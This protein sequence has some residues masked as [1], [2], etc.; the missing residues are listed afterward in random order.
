MRLL[1]YSCPGERVHNERS[2]ANRQRVRGLL[3]VS[4]CPSDDLTSLRDRRTPGT[5]KG[6]LSDTV[7]QKWTDC[8]RSSNI[9]W[10]YA[11]PGHGKSVQAAFL[12]DYFTKSGYKCPYY[13]FRHD[14]STKRSASSLLKSLAFQIARDIPAFEESLST[15]GEDGL[16]FE[17]MDARSIWHKLFL[18]ILFKMQ[19][20]DPLYWV[21]DALDESDSI[22]TVIDVLSTISSSNFPIHIIVFSRQ[23]PAISQGFDRI[24][25]VNPLTTINA[26]QNLDDIRLFAISEMKYMHGNGDFHKEIIDQIVNRAEGSFL[27][28]DLVLKEIMQCHSYEEIKIAFDEIPSGMDSL[29]RRMET[30]IKNLTRVSDKDLARTILILATYSRRPLTTDEMLQALQPQF[31]AVL[32]LRFTIS[33]VCG[34]FVTIDSNSHIGLVHRTAREYLTKSSELPFSISPHDAH[35]DLSSKTISIFLDRQIRSIAA[36]KPIIPFYAYSS[37]SWAYHLNFSSAASDATLTLLIRFLKGS[38][39][40]SWIHMLAVLGQLKVLIF[41]AQGLTTYVQKRRKS[42]ASKMPLLHRLSDLHILELWAIDLLKLTGKFGSHLLQ[43]PTGIYK[44]VPQFSPRN[45]ALFQ[46]FGTSNVSPLSVTGLSD[47]DWDDCLTRVSVGSEHQAL[48]AICSGR[49]LA[50]L[51]ST[52]TVQVWNSLTFEKMCTFSHQEHIFTMCFSLKG[53]MIATYGFLTTRIW[54]ITSKRQLFTIS[55]PTGIRPLCMMFTKNDATILMGSDIRN[56]REL[57][58]Q[59]V[60]QGWQECEISKFSEETP[61]KG[62]FSNAP[63]A[64]AINGDATEIAIAYRGSPLTVWALTEPKC[65]SKCKRRLEYDKNPANAWTGVN[66]VLWH[67]NSGE[68]LGIYVDGAVFKWH[69]FEGNHHELT[70]SS[71]DTPSELDCSL[72]GIV[73][74]TS[75]VNGTVKIYNYEHFALIYQLSSED[76]VT[77]LCFSPDIRRFYD[78]RGSYCNAWEPNVLIR[79]SNADEAVSDIDTEVGSTTVSYL[80]SEVWAEIRAPITAVSAK[81]QG[82]LVCTG[83]DEGRVELHDIVDRKKLVVGESAAEM[84]IDQIVWDE[85]GRH[86]ARAE[87]GGRIIIRSIQQFHAK[88]NGEFGW[89]C[90]PAVSFKASVE[91]GGIAQILFSPDSSF[92][93]VASLNSAQLWS[94]QS[95]SIRSVYMSPTPGV[96]Y[97]WV[98]HPSKKDD[99]LVFSAT[100]IIALGWTDLRKKGQWKIGLPTMMGGS[101]EMVAHRQ[102]SWLLQNSSGNPMS[103][104]GAGDAIDQVIM[105]QNSSYILTCLSQHSLQSNQSHR[106]RFYLIELN[107]L[108]PI[109]AEASA[110]IDATFPIP[111]SIAVTIEKPLTILGEDLLVYLDKSFWVCSC[112]IN[113]N[114]T[115]RLVTEDEHEH[116]HDHEREDA[117]TTRRHFFL[118]RDWVDAESL[119]L[120]RI[121]ADGTLL[122]P[123]KGELAV[124]R[125]D[126][127]SEW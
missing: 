67:P 53:E 123:R 97:K 52:G 73:F 51:S 22:S 19:G 5:C 14:D 114:N 118:P 43:E 107:S 62:T 94:L 121:M 113:I 40:L 12:I 89:S 8:T 68:L 79:M 20:I 87:L 16:R 102:C 112:R 15:M 103:P 3:G 50:V 85:A 23:T 57:S 27:W 38:H 75:D 45:S 76:M 69:P 47:S 44:Y 70:T 39:V 83:S 98:S 125:S 1:I 9:L 84:G 99:I 96:E 119:K 81:W 46:Q 55:N 109:T 42:D 90:E 92:L 18:S 127:G 4:D 49:Y 7:F 86:I 101:K 78:L 41:A 111:N 25:S 10:I 48:M 77:G 21:I 80:A 122:C 88:S 105:S 61:L 2:T 60:V 58:M 91:S 35:E 63:T 95:K 6:I 13:F 120:C 82:R 115:K 33:K 74:A 54:S 93:L 34:H 28:V 117:L 26:E 32:D 65:I 36:Q 108:K 124:V 71:R 17:K 104:L 116:E 106:S 37:T 126:L 11:R 72:D 59:N 110:S 66:R 64:M 30:S 100:T 24:S 29:Y 56:I 31:P